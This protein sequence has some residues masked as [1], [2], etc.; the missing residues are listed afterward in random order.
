MCL[1]LWSSVKSNEVACNWYNETELALSGVWYISLNSC[2]ALT[3]NCSPSWWLDLQ[4]TP[5]SFLL[6]LYPPPLQISNFL[7]W[8]G[9][10]ECTRWSSGT[11]PDIVFGWNIYLI[12]HHGQWD[13]LTRDPSKSAETFRNILEFLRFSPSY[14]LKWF[15]N[16]LQFQ[17]CSVK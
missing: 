4:K 7:Y 12:F 10:S 5:V 1:R 14:V 15:G 3:R 13:W 9:M 16:F 8:N 17:E 6:E 11:R 2:S